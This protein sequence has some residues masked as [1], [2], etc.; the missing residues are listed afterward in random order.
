[1]EN[2]VWAEQAGQWR[3]FGRDVVSVVNHLDLSRIILIGHGLS[4]PVII[5]AAS[6]IPE[7]L[8]GLVGVDTLHDLEQKPM[9]VDQI[10]AYLTPMKTDFVNTIRDAVKTM[11][12][13]SSDAKLVE[14]IAVDM[15]SAPPQVGIG[16][17]EELL[18]YPSLVTSKNFL[19]RLVLIN[20]SE[21]EP[22]NLESAQRYGVKVRLVENVGHF[23]MIENSEKFNRIL[24][25]IISG[26]LVAES[27]SLDRPPE[28]DLNA[29]N[30][31]KMIAD[32]AIE[33]HLQTQR[34]PTFEIEGIDTNTTSEGIRR[35]LRK[36]LA[37]ELYMELNE[38]DDR[39]PF[40]EM[41]LDSISAVSWIRKINSFYGLSISA[42]Q[43]YSYPTIHAFA[44]F[45]MEEFKQQGGILPKPEKSSNPILPQAKKFNDSLK[46]SPYSTLNL[47]SFHRN[48]CRE[49]QSKD[50][51]RVSEIKKGA[52]D[53]HQRSRERRSSIAVIGMSGQFPKAKSLAEY[54]NNIAH[55]IDCI[56]E[57]PEGRWTMRHY[58]DPNPRIPGKSYSQWMG[59]LDDVDQF[60]PLFFNISPREAESMDPQQRLFLQECWHCIEDAGY[61][62]SSLSGSRCGV[63]VGCAHSSYG[64]LLEGK[65]VNSQGVLGVDSSILAGR[66]SYQFNLK[67]PCLAID[68]ACSASLVAL[69]NGCDSL[70]WGNSDM[71]LTG[72]VWIITG[73]EVHIQMS[74]TG[75]LSPEGRCFAFDQRANGFVPGEGVG[76]VL[77][78]RLADAIKDGDNIY[79][80]IRGWSVNQDGK[81]NGITAPNGGFT[82]A[83]RKRSVRKVFD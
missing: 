50:N 3:A 20:S 2:Q 77:L 82:N 55:R 48:H 69:A 18:R 45:I 43:I 23:C 32:D 30:I 80:V 64:Q 38:I 10:A 12:L 4:G 1:M 74:Q 41:G 5:E 49:A 29:N 75:A 71:V 63:L 39:M 81:T 57:I 68:T 17:M 26:F 72:G 9:T 79:G 40:T 24:E 6:M 37:G 83:I 47:S 27:T 66:I 76:V 11:F 15:S 53:P 21:F 42:T 22:T 16:A 14:R 33:S 7:K 70:S 34:H 52:D 35:T 65:K 61:T 78:K 28:K 62:P 67:G 36:R 58:Y 54:W 59:V 60:D 8:I 56:S 31:K 19:S 46:E 13:N 25:E 73:P 44:S 51:T